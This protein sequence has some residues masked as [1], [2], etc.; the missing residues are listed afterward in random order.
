MLFHAFDHLGGH[1]HRHLP[2]HPPVRTGD[3]QIF[4]RDLQHTG[5]LGTERGIRVISD[6]GIPQI[7]IFPVIIIEHTDFA[8]VRIVPAGSGCEKIFLSVP[9]KIGR[10]FPRIG[11]KQSFIV[12]RFFRWMA[13][14]SGYNSDRDGADPG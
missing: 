5:D 9:I 1:L 14:P 4:I 8:L 13:F 3:I 2:R 7:L 10:R 6:M 11:R 12:F